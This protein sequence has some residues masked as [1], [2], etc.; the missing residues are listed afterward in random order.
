MARWQQA[1]LIVCGG[2]LLAGF[3][4]PL[5][6]CQEVLAEKQEKTKATVPAVR[7]GEIQ[8]RKYDFKKAGSAKGCGP[9]G[10]CLP[11]QGHVGESIA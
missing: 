2:V 11:G 10:E 8:T 1:C 7:K 6:A 5:Q 9:L 4:T 3:L